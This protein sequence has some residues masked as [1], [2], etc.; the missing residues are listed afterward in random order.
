[1]L[2]NVILWGNVRHV[3]SILG[4][5]VKIEVLTVVVKRIFQIHQRFVADID[6]AW[7]NRTLSA[8]LA[9]SEGGNIVP[10]ERAVAYNM[11]IIMLSGIGIME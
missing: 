11:N 6:R 9:D 2:Y 4:Q 10:M 1:M 5:H 8:W 7:S 3:K